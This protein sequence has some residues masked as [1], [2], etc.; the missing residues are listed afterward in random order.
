MVVEDE[1][2]IVGYGCAA[3]DSR[4]FRTKQS[5]SWIPEM[6]LKYPKPDDISELSK[7][8]QVSIFI[9]FRNF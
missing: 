1:S 4:K 7:F 2:G 5:L 6:C 3:L 8:V 9:Y